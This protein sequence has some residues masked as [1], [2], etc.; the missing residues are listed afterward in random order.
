MKRWLLALVLLAACDRRAAPPAAAPA[1]TTTPP[2]SPARV[3]SAAADTS[4]PPAPPGVQRASGTT[5]LSGKVVVGGIEGQLQT[6]LQ[7]GNGSAVFLTGALESELRSLAGATVSVTGAETRRDNRRSVVVESYEITDVDGERPAVG[8][9]LAGNRL[10]TATD[11]LIVT[12]TI[13]APAG[14][15]VWIT[16]DRTGKQIAVR[17]F[18][19]IAR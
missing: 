3:D 4:R 12:G 17:S 15:K 9:F 13:N 14:A 5:P 16:G 6:T 7:P 8:R 18:G 11:T 2:A 19:I 10:A 1:D